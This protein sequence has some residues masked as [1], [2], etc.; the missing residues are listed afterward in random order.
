MS[1][2]WL[3]KD[4]YPQ[5]QQNYSNCNALD[6]K[7]K[8][9]FCYCVADFKKSFAFD[10]K[11]TKVE[12]TVSADNCFRLFVNGDFTGSGP[13]LPGGDFLCRRPAP[14]HYSN[15]Y[16]VDIQSERLELFAK[17]RLLPDKVCDY[18][19]SRGGFMLHGVLFFEDGETRTVDADETWLCR[20]DSAYT[21]F[22]AFDSSKPE[23]DFSAASVIR[24]IWNAEKS[25]IPMLSFETVCDR[26]FT[27]NAGEEN[28]FTAELD[29]IWGAYPLL[30]S[31][32]KAS[33][34]VETCEL[35]GQRVTAE[36]AFFAKPG[37]YFSFRM[38]S[39]G[40]VRVKIKNN[41]T[42][43]VNA[44]L[45]LLASH[46]PVKEEGSFV[47]S[48]PG[49]NKVF[50][51]CKHTLK[52]CRQTIHLDSPQHQELL[53]CTGDYYIDMLMT[54]YMF[55]D[56][57]LAEFDLIR[58][59]D[60]IT[61]N[62]GRM[63]HTTYSLIWVQMLRD[64]YLFTGSAELLVKCEKALDTLFFRFDSY[65]GTSGVIEYPPDF[66]F[67]DWTVVDGYSMH[68]PPKALGQTVLN[69]FYYEALTSAAEIYGHLQNEEK[70]NEYLDRAAAF[71]ECFNR[72]F[73]DAD[74]KLYFDGK[75]D[76]YGGFD[77]HLPNNS[78][79]RYYTKYPN[80]LACAY[81]LID[82]DAAVSLLERVIFN[83][84]MQDIQPYFT[85]YLLRAL[86]RLGLFGK[87]G[88]RLLERW[89]PVVYECD[90]GLKEGWI[91]PQPDYSFDHS[92]SWGGIAGYSLPDSLLH[93][94]IIEPGMK[95]LSFTPELYG[96]DYADIT[97]PTPYGMIRAA[98]R[99]GE[100][101]VITVPDGIEIIMNNESGFDFF[102]G[103]LVQ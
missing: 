23:Y 61:A 64:C 24:D 36:T 45:R 103:V 77:V 26:H 60:W 72:E 59:A 6:D 62:C 49:F 42:C 7:E 82:G 15:F 10:K 89:K 102:C 4:L 70:K 79:K 37:E 57:R 99:K 1:W 81:G 53:A 47:C 41:D 95:K 20:P 28:V 3:N 68:H 50:D 54:L 34:T 88:F 91:A 9:R 43:A 2:I 46:Y 40:F 86:D 17:V 32:G 69:A 98:L 48:D 5:F 58:T 66:M 78:P 87:Y 38:H 55:G 84:E 29:K 44:E 65:F 27:V 22:L 76:A 33:V 92:H 93:M 51:V 94:R 80:I 8:E 31:S 90:K 63:F 16:T 25:P 13:V 73:Y 18:S 96:L 21:D 71:R 100:K 56:M 101:P 39:V 74:K 75:N 11:I 14:K 97:F 67:V 35:D 30:T 83:G 19:R 85:S 52:I 12:L